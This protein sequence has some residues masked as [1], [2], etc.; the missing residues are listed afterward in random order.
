MPALTGSPVP[1]PDLRHEVAEYGNDEW[2]TVV[3]PPRYPDGDRP[4]DRFI[5]NMLDAISP[6]QEATP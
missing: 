3:Y 5:E 6:P 1:K 4:L 2:G